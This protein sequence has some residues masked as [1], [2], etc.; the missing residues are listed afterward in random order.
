MVRVCVRQSIT[1]V[2]LLGNQTLG[3]LEQ[4]VPNKQIINQVVQQ[5]GTTQILL[6]LLVY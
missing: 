3:K 6:G 2:M 1:Q 5:V 4:S